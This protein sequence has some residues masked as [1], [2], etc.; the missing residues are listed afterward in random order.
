MKEE[1]KK[2]AYDYQKRPDYKI[3]VERQKHQ[4]RIEKNKPVT[5]YTGFS[6][7]VKERFHVAT[8]NL[9]EKVEGKVK[10]TVKR[11]IEAEKQRVIRIRAEKKAY[12]KA[13]QN[14]R[15]KYIGQQAREKF[16]VTH[17]KVTQEKAAT[18]L[19]GSSLGEG[20]FGMQP[21]KSNQTPIFDLGFKAQNAKKKKKEYNVVWGWQ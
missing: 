19:F 21:Q 9:G 7:K 1:K 14:A 20:F 17:P 10:E 13:Y 11:G 2:F 6:G 15:I 16:K 5:F 4:E 3:S 8:R 12:E 18:S